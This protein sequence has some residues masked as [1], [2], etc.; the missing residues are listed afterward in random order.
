MDVTDESGKSEKS[1]KT[2]DFGEAHNTQRPRRLVNLWV[3][4]FLHDEKNI[5]HR[6]GWDE[7]H[8]KPGPQVLLLDLFGVQNDLGVV[9]EDDARAEVE[10]QVHEEESVRHHVEDNPGR[11]GLVFEEGDAHRNDN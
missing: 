2:K 9:L 11:G 5:I 1:Q 4:P 8:N 7:V 6:D 3:D 10:H